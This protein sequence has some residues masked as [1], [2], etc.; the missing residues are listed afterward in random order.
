[1]PWVS[2][3][4]FW[5]SLFTPWSICSVR[6]PICI[7]TST[8]R[9]LAK[10]HWSR[11]FLTQLDV[12]F[13]LDIMAFGPR[14]PNSKIFSSFSSL[15]KRATRACRTCP[16]SKLAEVLHKATICLHTSCP[17]WKTRLCI[18]PCIWTRLVILSMV[19]LAKNGC[20]FSRAKNSCQDTR[21][22]LKSI[23]KEPTI[24]F[25]KRCLCAS[26]HSCASE[27]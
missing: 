13:L 16:P 2:V 27:P 15:T 19:R 9:T 12:L 14:L 3:E 26:W 10:H 4:P 5:S 21:D 23:W 18:L 20:A 22:S 17:L 7:S 25:V 8:S 6:C 24:R 1:L 11:L